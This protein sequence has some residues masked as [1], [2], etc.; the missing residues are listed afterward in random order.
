MDPATLTEISIVGA[1]DAG[2][3]MLKATARRKLEYVLEKKRQEKVR[4]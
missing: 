4:R 3:A 2:E 1:P